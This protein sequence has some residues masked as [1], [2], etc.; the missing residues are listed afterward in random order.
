[1]CNQQ[2]AQVLVCNAQ[3]NPNTSILVAFALVPGR[4]GLYLVGRLVSMFL[5]CLDAHDS[6][7]LH[8]C[9]ASIVLS[10]LNHTALM[11]ATP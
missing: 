3:W 1:M 7:L 2:A 11:C 5:A 9:N 10:C 6:L 8:F 4:L